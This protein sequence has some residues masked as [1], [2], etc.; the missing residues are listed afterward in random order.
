MSNDKKQQAINALVNRRNEVIAEM[1]RTCPSWQ[2]KTLRKLQVLS[3][4]LVDA[5]GRVEAEPR[6]RDNARFNRTFCNCDLQ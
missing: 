2:P 3:G 4:V 1:R 6:E 5:I